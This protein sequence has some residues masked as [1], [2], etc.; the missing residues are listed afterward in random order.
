MA[1]LIALHEARLETYRGIERKDF[2]GQM[3]RRQQIQ[4]ALLQRGI[5]FQ[6]D[7]LVWGRS[8]LPLLAAEP[9][10]SSD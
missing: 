6:E 5:R 9:A 1:R 3:D 2:S 8:L 7:W 4:Y 10:G